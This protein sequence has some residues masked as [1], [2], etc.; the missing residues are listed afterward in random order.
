MP[1]ATL[2]GSPSKKKK[3][4]FCHVR[5]RVQGYS[6]HIK[7]CEREHL[8]RQGE[9]RYVKELKKRLHIDPEGAGAAPPNQSLSRGSTAADQ[10]D[11]DMGLETLDPVRELTPPSA[12]QTT[13]PLDGPTTD[14]VTTE[15]HPNSRRLPE[16][17]SFEEYGRKHRF[18]SPP[19]N[20]EPWRPFFN[21]REDF[22]FAEILLE[23]GMNKD[24]SERL[25]KLFNL[26]LDGK[27]AFTFSNYSDIQAAWGRA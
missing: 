4:Q 9:R 6:S 2:S 11:F 3:C 14:E 1:K 16:T 7:R 13:G 8:E 18:F 22:V 12:T 27:G 15:Y 10:M 26:C 17:Q 25:V 23:A 24:Q 5:Y 21:S 19:P 20:A